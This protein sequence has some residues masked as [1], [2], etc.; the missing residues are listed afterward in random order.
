MIIKD[1]LP[2]HPAIYDL[3][4]QRTEEQGRTFNDEIDITKSDSLKKVGFLWE[5]TPEGSNFWRAIN[6]GYFERFYQK[7]PKQNEMYSIY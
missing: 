7:Y 2:E 4:K 6:D 5:V 3:I 1:L